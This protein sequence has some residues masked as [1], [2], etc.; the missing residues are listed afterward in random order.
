MSH[1]DRIPKLSLNHSNIVLLASWI[2]YILH[3]YLNGG[4]GHLY[5]SIFLKIELSLV[6]E[7]IYELF[8]IEETIS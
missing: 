7:L 8:K 1:R 2:H 4:I 3:L 5:N 6:K